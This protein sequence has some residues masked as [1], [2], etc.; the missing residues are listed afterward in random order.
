ML[1][2]W[3]WPFFLTDSSPPSIVIMSL[4]RFVDWS[5]WSLLMQLEGA[6]YLT[7]PSQSMAAASLTRASAGSS[8]PSIK[9]PSC[10]VTWV[11]RRSSRAPVGTGRALVWSSSLRMRMSWRLY[12]RPSKANRR[13]AAAT[14]MDGLSPK[15]LA[16][17][18]C[19]LRSEILSGCSASAK[20]FHILGL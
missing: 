10:F 12:V 16:R 14:P 4:S 15:A 6:R 13:T 8:S 17:T 9:S 19:S 1:V 5:S 18:S 20:S 11:L 2:D 7:T 3:T